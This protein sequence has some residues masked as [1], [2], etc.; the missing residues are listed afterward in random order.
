MLRAARPASDADDQPVLVRTH[1][2]VGNH[3]WFY[4]LPGEAYDA[5]RQKLV[6]QMGLANRGGPALPARHYGKR[7]VACRPCAATR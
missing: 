5:L 6:D 1:Y 4:H 3:D 7:R 2:M